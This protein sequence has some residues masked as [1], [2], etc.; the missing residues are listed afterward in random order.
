MA[1]RLSRE[2]GDWRTTSRSP[3]F[4]V[5][6]RMGKSS[7]N[8]ATTAAATVATAL[9]D[10]LRE[11]W[12]AISSPSDPTLARSRGASRATSSQSP[13]SSSERARSNKRLASR[14]R[15]RSVIW[16]PTWLASTC[17]RRPR[18]IASSTCWRA[19]VWASRS[20]A[21]S[22]LSAGA[23]SAG[24]APICA[25]RASAA[26]SFGVS[27]AIE[28]S[29][30]SVIGSMRARR[31]ASS[32]S[33]RL[34]VLSPSRPSM[35]S[36]SLRAASIATVGSGGGALCC[37]CATASDMASSAEAMSAIRNGIADRR[38]VSRM[39]LVWRS[40]EGSGAPS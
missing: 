19:A 3:K 17:S 34:R 1:E 5:Q 39:G 15:R 31:L 27:S 32:S 16:S 30:D 18:L 33:P 40:H 25:R 2:R 29:S 26:A 4:A 28:A 10:R 6:I 22:A 20:L 12:S 11:T 37:P 9:V 38:T 13:G 14:A 24:L 36:R 23:P 21:T 35:R 8:A 7:R